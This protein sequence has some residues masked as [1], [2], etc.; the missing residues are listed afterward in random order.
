[1]ETQLIQAVY[2]HWRQVKPKKNDAAWY[3]IIR[4]YLAPVHSLAAEEMAKFIREG[5]QHPQYSA[6]DCI[7]TC[8]EQITACADPQWDFIMSKQYQ[9]KPHD[10]KTTQWK[11]WRMTDEILV[12]NRPA[13]TEPKDEL[14]E[15]TQ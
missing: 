11:F 4:S 15:V 9:Y 13:P 8:E 12:N 10:Y 2:D 6:W 5:H 3:H 7:K 1:M 14:F